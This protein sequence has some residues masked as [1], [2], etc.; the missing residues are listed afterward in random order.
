ME[1]RHI[2]PEEQERAIFIISQS[3]YYDC[4]SEYKLLEKGK[5]RYEDFFGAFNDEG[6]MV[7]VIQ[8]GPYYMWLDGKSVMCGGI[9]NVATLPEARRSGAIRRLMKNIH[10]AM[11]EQGYVMGYLYPFS[12]PYYRQFGYELCNEKHHLEASPEPLLSLDFNG[13]AKQFEPGEE[14][15]DPSDIIEIYTLFSRKYNIML[16]RDAWQWEQKLEH[17]PVTTKT[18]TYIIYNNAEKACAYF[19]YEH[20]RQGFTA[21]L[22]IKDMAWIDYDSMYLLFAFIGRLS[23]NVIKIGFDVP[24]E[25]C[26]SYLFSESHSYELNIKPNGMA[27]IINA[28]KALENMIKPNERGIFKIKIHDEFMPQNDKTYKVSWKNGHTEVTEFSGIC[29]MECSIMALTQMLTGYVGLDVAQ[30]RRD[31]T[32][33]S[34]EELLFLSFPKKMVCIADY[35]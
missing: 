2:T 26:P 13:S 20:N 32:V 21:S 10:D 28:K 18:R 29:D 19:T 35:F 9:G 17:D 3:F 16:D 5:F 12:H 11:F 7:A 8:R 31:V 24:A 34:N 27:R 33:K 6:E 14:G 1:F 25:I 23:G 22:E 15:T 4:E 30:A